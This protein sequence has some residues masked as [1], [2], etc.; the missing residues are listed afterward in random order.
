M[1][2]TNIKFIVE[3]ESTIT[4]QGLED[5]ERDISENI[6]ECCSCHWRFVGTSVRYGFGYTSESVDTPNFCPMCGKEI[7]DITE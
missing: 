6:Y 2:D 7:K 5:D 1:E 4:N 3:M